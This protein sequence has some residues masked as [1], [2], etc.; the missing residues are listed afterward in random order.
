MGL[1]FLAIVGVKF[2]YHEQW[3]DEWQAWF[4]ARDLNV[5]DLLGFLYYEG[6]P[7][8]WYLWM[9]PFSLVVPTGDLGLKLAHLVI[10]A[11]FLYTWIRSDLPSWVKIVGLLAYPFFF[12]YGVVSRSY[13]LVL[14]LAFAWSFIRKH[15]S[16]WIPFLLF[17]LCQTAIQG[18]FVAFAIMVYHFF[19]KGWGKNF[20]KIA[21]GAFI[22]LVAFVVTVYPRDQQEDLA[23]AY[24]ADPSTLDS[25]WAAFQ[26]TTANVFF[27]GILPDTNVFGLSVQGLLLGLLALVLCFYVLRSSRAALTLFLAYWIPTFLFHAII[28]NGGLRQWSMVFVVFVLALSIAPGLLKSRKNLLIAVA[29]FLGPLYYNGRAIIKEVTMPF[30]NSLVTGEFIKEKV[31]ESVPVV[32]INKFE[33]SPVGGYAERA[34]FALPDGLPFTYFKWVEKIYIPTEAELR[35]FIDYKGVGGLVVISPVELDQARFPGLQ[36]WQRFDQ[37]SIK[38]ENYILYTLKKEEDNIGNQR[39]FPGG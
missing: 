14:L 7:A 29:L 16:Q 10:F 4:L 17:L 35:L 8:L 22:G 19:E 32:A 18:V 5:P 27:M 20:I 38:G 31:P 23:F 37:P 13:I 15:K 28:Y 21:T 30:S 36:E 6:H 2:G 11:G 24:S 26:G 1:I 3:K 12:E 9:K 39:V 33:C 25:W 34:F